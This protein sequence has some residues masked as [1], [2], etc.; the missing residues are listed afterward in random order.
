[1][2][3]ERWRLLFHLHFNTVVSLQSP[4]ITM[5]SMT[6]FSNITIK[7]SRNS[8]FPLGP[9]VSLDLLYSQGSPSSLVALLKSLLP[10]DPYKCYGILVVPIPVRPRSNSN[11]SIESSSLTFKFVCLDLLAVVSRIDHNRS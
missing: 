10:R 6:I 7:N 8:L 3:I 4:W 9:L 5:Y 1:M 11:V 2:I